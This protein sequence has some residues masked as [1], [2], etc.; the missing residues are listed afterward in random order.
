MAL[1]DAGIAV[2]AV[3]ALAPTTAQLHERIREMV[4]PARWKLL[5]QLIA[6]YPSAVS[7]GELA[8]RAGVASASSG[9]ANNL[10]ALRTL[11]LIDYPSPGQVAVTEVL[12]L[13]GQSVSGKR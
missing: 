12:F 9:Y 8:E 11:G 4:P 3:P 13:N 5:E 10:G 7:R 6:M 1:T 2:A